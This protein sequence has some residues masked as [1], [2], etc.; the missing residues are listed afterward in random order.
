MNIGKNIVMNSDYSSSIVIGTGYS[1][2]IISRKENKKLLEESCK[3][4]FQAAFPHVYE[5]YGI[6][7]DAWTWSD[8]H[9]ALS[10][11]AFIDKLP[12]NHDFGGK[13][14][15]IFIPKF[16][17]IEYANMCEY[18]NYVGSS[19]VWRNYAQSE[20]YYGI[21][22]KIHKKRFISFREIDCYTTK[23]MVLQPEKTKDCKNIFNNPVERFLISKPVLGSFEYK[24][25]NSLEGIWGRENKLTSF[26]FPIL[27]HLGCKN[28]GVVGFDFGGG[29]FYDMKNTTHAFD[30]KDKLQDPTCKIVKTWTKE[31]YKYHN[32]K[33]YSLAKQGESGLVD[34]LH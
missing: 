20:A 7:P 26:V 21:L 6:M 28:L 29:R 14:L 10:G 5:L 32:M 4:A 17:G 15:E 12:D 25:D 3:I 9:A 13:K 11:L 27:S 34:I 1:T 18:R 19:P 22:D 30:I 31:W 2:S 23:Q 24:T 8:P 16:L 33:V